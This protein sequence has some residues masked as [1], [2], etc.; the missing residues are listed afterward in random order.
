MLGAVHAEPQLDGA[1]CMGSVLGDS[2]TTWA[3]FPNSTA[4]RQD[5]VIRVSADNGR[6]WRVR[7]TNISGVW[8]CFDALVR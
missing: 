3:S 2:T 5:G 4:G 6:S 7:H 1:I 8:G